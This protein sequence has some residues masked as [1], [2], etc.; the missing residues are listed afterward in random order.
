MWYVIFATD[1]E[2]SL[3]LRQSVRP[4]HLSRLEAL[5]NQG[6]LL[7][8]GPMPALDTEDPGEA[9]FT[10]STVIAEFDSLEH[11]QQWANSDPY[12]EAGVYS[13]VIVKPFKKVL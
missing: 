8:A 5:R 11:A 4:E 10:G 1:V 3:P 7:T 13:N 2:N 12:I 6:R 9:G